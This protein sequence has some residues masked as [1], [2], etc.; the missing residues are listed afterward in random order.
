MCTICGGCARAASGAT[1]R[2]SHE[3]LNLTLV[4]VSEGAGVMPQGSYLAAPSEGRPRRFPSRGDGRA[5]FVGSKNKCRRRGGRS[6]RREEEEFF[7]HYKNDLERH[8]HTP[9]GVA[10][11]DLKSQSGGALRTPTLSR[12]S[13]P[14]T[15]TIPLPNLDLPRAGC[16]SPGGHP[17]VGLWP[18]A[19]ARPDV[20]PGL[21]S[22]A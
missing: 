21:A 5:D 18:S 22:C 16:N 2:D 15:C 12:F 7:N 20:D 1:Q 14:M 11:A 3:L 19:A 9:S 6:A 4:T 10:G 8:A 17:G 13:P